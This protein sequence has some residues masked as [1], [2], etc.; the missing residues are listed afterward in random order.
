MGVLAEALVAYAQPLID[1]TDGSKEQVGRA[2]ALS[3]M[4]YQVALLP[5]EE[6]DAAIDDLREKLEMDPAE[7]AKFRKDVIRP[8]IQRHKEMF[9]RLHALNGSGI[10]EWGE[11][12]EPARPQRSER[13]EAYPGTDRYAPCPCDSGKKYKFCCG[14]KGA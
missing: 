2:F 1:L 4:C 12:V 14:K 9:P 11:T 6:R 8:M 10:P 3:Q 5:E 13:G 7:Y